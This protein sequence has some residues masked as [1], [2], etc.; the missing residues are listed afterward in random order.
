M[1]MLVI[2]VPTTP[3]TCSSRPIGRAPS[4][5]ATQSPLNK[6]PGH[7]PF[8]NRSVTIQGNAK[9]GM[10]GPCTART[11]A[12][13]VWPHFVV[14]VQTI[15]RT[16]NGHHVGA[17][18]VKHLGQCGRPHHAQHPPRSSGPLERQVLR[19][20]AFCRIDVPPRC[21]IIESARFPSE[22][23]SAHTG[24][25]VR[26]DRQLPGIGELGPWALKNLMPLSGKALWLA[27]ITTPRLA[28]WARQIRHAR[29]GQR[30]QQQHIHPGR[31]KARLQRAISS[32]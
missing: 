19:E 24:S 9:V 27:E 12:S 29:C 16:T 18:L 15:G 32:M 2:S 28:R 22:A 3:G 20:G 23:E 6:R 26:L 8:C 11:R 7:P 10:V 4:G 30:P 5:R 1:A 13:D 25:P 31:V 14:D 21:I 17:Q